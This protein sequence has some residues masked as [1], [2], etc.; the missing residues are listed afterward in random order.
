MLVRADR[1]D[2]ARVFDRGLSVY[3]YN[4]VINEI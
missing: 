4:G 2:L 1:T 3:R